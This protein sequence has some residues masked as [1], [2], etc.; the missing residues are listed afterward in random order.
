VSEADDKLEETKAMLADLT[1]KM[2][3]LAEAEKAINSD[4]REEHRRLNALNSKRLEID[5]ASAAIR[6]DFNEAKRLIEQQEKE[7]ATERENER[8]R[9]EFAKQNA[10]FD[11]QMLKYEWGGKAKPHQIDAGKKLAIAGRG[12]LGDKRGL[13]KTL[14]SI[15]FCDLSG[16]RKVLCIVPNDVRGNF[17]REVEYWAPHRSVV[18]LGGMSKIQRNALLDVFKTLTDIFVVINYEA[19]RKDNALLQKL[20]AVHFDTVI[21]D[22]AHMMKEM[23]T[24]AF[25]GVKTVVAAENECPVCGSDN[26]QG[27]Y[28]SPEKHRHVRRCYDCHAEQEKFGDFC[29]V[30]KVLPMT[31]TPILN[32]PQDIFPLLHLVNP[33]TFRDKKDFLNTYCEKGYDGKWV[34]QWGGAERLATRLSGMYVARDRYQAGVEIPKQSIQIHE[35]DM[36]PE[37][38]PKQ[39]EAYQILKKKSSL[40]VDDMLA[41]DENKA[42]KPIL[43][44]IALITRLR[45]MSV[46]PAGIEFRHPKTKELLFK[47]DVTESVKLDYI[48][49]REGNG[50]APQLINDEQERVVLFSQFKQPLIELE[51]RLLAAGISVVRYDGDTPDSLR[52][53]IQIDFDRKYQEEGQPY[54][55]DIVLGHYKTGGTG[56]NL[57]AATQMIILD[58]EWNPGKEDQAYGRID[59]MG[60]NEETTVHVLRN[61]GTIDEWMA[62]LIAQKRNMIEGFETH[63]DLEQELL[64]ILRGI[65]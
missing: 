56:I 48:I 3:E 44:M 46:W 65:K 23:D 16:A 21:A 45:Q 42:V 20:I 62:N 19:W 18:D 39:W 25:R 8:V 1:V 54:R 22:E 35:L 5:N 9:L 37:L 49:D 53:Q 64:D 57:N 47:T 2:A 14:S 59:R 51:R 10:F 38:Y 58:E 7:A 26:F 31:G 27:D 60:Q 50:L 12:I 33:V 6:R 11:E 36:D 15:I 63:I 61:T 17:V 29:S 52:Q 28:W 34:F 41:E 55:W 24:N 30:K 43:Y 13:G 4:I 40:I 32:K